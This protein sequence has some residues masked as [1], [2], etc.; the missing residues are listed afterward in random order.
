[1]TAPERRAALRRASV[2]IDVGRVPE[3]AALYADLLHQEP[4]DV[5]SLCGLSRC[6]GK[7]D[8]TRQA[9]E[10]AE[11]AVALAPDDDWPHRL[12]SAHL[13]RLRRPGE[14]ERAAR[15]AVRLDPLGF[16]PLLTLFETQAGRRDAGGAADTANR[17]RELFP[18]Q[19]EAWSG[20]A[21][22]ER[23]CSCSTRR[24]GRI[25]ATPAPGGSWSWRSTAAWRWP[26]S[27][28]AWPGARW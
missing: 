10:L 16:A 8:R 22:G 3:A 15:E 13:M 28:A 7:L 18:G 27:A 25:P 23:R 20:A 2:L 9:L 19:A 5:G 12:R 1:M 24:C 4:D 21:A 17:I 14:A 26:A 6:L 11:R